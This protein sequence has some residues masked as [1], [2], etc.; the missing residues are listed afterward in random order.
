MTQLHW[1]GAQKYVGKRDLLGRT[2]Y[3]Y[4]IDTTPPE[5]TIEID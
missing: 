4:R 5:F 3:L 1:G 2:M